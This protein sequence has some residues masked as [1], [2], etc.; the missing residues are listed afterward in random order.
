M[1][2]YRKVLVIAGLIVLGGFLSGC[3]GTLSQTVDLYKSSVAE[4]KADEAYQNKDFVTAFQEYKTAAQAGSPYGQF[5]LAN[6]YLNG[7]GVQRDT[8][9]YS[10]WIR[11]AAEN[12][13]PAAHYFIGMELI[14]SDSMLAVR[15]L[16]QAAAL[17]HGPSM[18]LLGLMHAQGIGVP[19]SN[20]EAVRWFRLAH[21]HGIQ[22]DSQ[23]LSESG[24][25]AYVKKMNQAAPSTRSTNRSTGQQLVRQVQQ[26]LTDL[27]YAP[28]PID[29]MFGGKTKTAIQEFQRTKGLYPDGK[30]TPQLLEMLKN[31][32]K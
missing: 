1:I 14:F 21:A 24:I 11:Q 20:R 7:E 9:Q 30:A 29:G 15:H 8:K 25:Q 4:E 6:M 23:L 18:H 5:M 28:G 22:V 13:S 19:Q 10:Y 17:E 27:G 32:G 26:R 16:E 12:G 3:A 2:R 31:T